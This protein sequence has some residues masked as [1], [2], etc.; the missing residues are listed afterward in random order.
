MDAGCP[1][2]ACGLVVR[3]KILQVLLVGVQSHGKM[4][5]ASRLV[6]K[7]PGPYFTLQ[8]SEVAWEPTNQPLGGASDRF[9][10]QQCGGHG[11]SAHN[12]RANAAIQ[13]YSTCRVEYLHRFF[14]VF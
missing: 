14:L 2:K 12:V 9:A 6:P 10:Q 13:Q 11:A 1:A 3:P 7:T 4:I 8:F 5:A